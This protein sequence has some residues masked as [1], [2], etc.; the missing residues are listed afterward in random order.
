VYVLPFPYP[1]WNALSTIWLARLPVD[2]AARCWFGLNLLMLMGAIAVLTREQ[3][4]LKRVLLFMGAILW[5]PA[6]GG[7]IVGQFGF[8]VLLGAALMVWALREQKHIL[9]VLAAVLLS[10]K[11][12]LGFVV[13]L[14]AVSRLFVQR[15]PFA[16]RAL[17]GVIA[18]AVILFG[19][20]F[21]ASPSWP[22]EYVSSLLGFKQVHGVPEC[23]QCVSIPVV[24]S[25]ALGGGLSQ[26]AWIALIL[27]S[28][29]CSWLVW[30]RKQVWATASSLVAIGVSATLLVS[31]Y[32][33]NYDYLLL[34]VPLIVLALEAHAA[35]EWIALGI[36]YVIPPAA[37][38]IWGTAGNP[39]LIIS[40]LIVA[41]LL[42]WHTVP[43]A[44]GSS[45]E[46][47]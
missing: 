46:L 10:F 20:G 27:A 41:A 7:L 5:L 33:L 12:H 31:P 8:P 4:P 18:A 3:A 42:L 6:L 13:V 2:M 21:L 15:D 47:A 25:R 36:A 32:L 35:R 24:A 45:R 23:T 19:L 22:S 28:L 30:R 17:W 34:L 26:A 11:P 9:F 39:A 38:A 14:L 37:L 43:A 1:P 44:D 16:R 40:T 29:A